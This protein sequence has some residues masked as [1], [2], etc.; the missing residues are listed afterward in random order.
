MAHD[1]QSLAQIFDAHAVDVPP[2][3]LGARLQVTTEEGSVTVRITEVEAYGDQGEDPGAHGF[4]GQTPRNASLFG[5]PRHAYVYRSYGIHFCLNLVSHAAGA[6][7]VLLRAGD[8]LEGREL[9]VRR[10]GGKDTGAK[11]LS[12]PGRLGQGLGVELGMDGTP[13][14]ILDDIPAPLP[15]PSSGV[16]LTLAPPEEAVAA[17]QISTGPRVGVSGEGGTSSYP[18]RFWIAGSRSVSPYRAS[19]PRRAAQK[20]R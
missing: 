14:E 3:V 6:G 19:K 10:R 1:A 13:L 7:G 12:G 20:D 8:V 4:N 17:D 11:L 5:P 2:H 18:W 9:A 15:G 16:R